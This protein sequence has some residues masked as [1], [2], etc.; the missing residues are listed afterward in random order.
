MTATARCPV[1]PRYWRDL[2][3]RGFTLIELLIALSLVALITVL[4]FSGLRL[5]SR[6]WEGVEQASE[7]NAEQ[8]LAR[9]FLERTLHQARAATVRLEDGERLVFAGGPQSLELVAPLSERVG[10]PGLYL[11]RFSLQEQGQ[12]TALVLTR[13]LFHPD[14]LLGNAD[15]PAWEPLAEARGVSGDAFELEQDLAGGAYGTTVLL[16]DVAALEIAYLGPLAGEMEPEWLD[17]WLDQP[18]LPVWVSLRIATPNVTWPEL[19]IALPGGF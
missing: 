18:T 12:R 10:I 7:L 16:P 6:A 3:A 5:G 4:L 1:E 15:V 2:G 14:I 8:R 13:W 9:S 11:L 19:L 17:E